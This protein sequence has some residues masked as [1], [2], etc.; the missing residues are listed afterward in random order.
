MERGQRPGYLLTKRD[1][2]WLDEAVAWQWKIPARPAP[3][4]R[5][6][7]VR[8]VRSWVMLFR[9]YVF[10]L[11]SSSDAWRELWRREWLAYA[12]RRGWC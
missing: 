7:G 3:I 5:A 4:W 1:H 11:P 12:I 9:A 10:I 2:E 6:W 8:H